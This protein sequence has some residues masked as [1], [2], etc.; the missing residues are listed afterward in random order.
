MFLAC[1]GIF[2]AP[3]ALSVGHFL[4]YSNP[5]PKHVDALAPPYLLTIQLL[6]AT[7]ASPLLICAGAVVRRV[8]GTPMLP[9][10]RALA[11]YA[12]GLLTA[13]MLIF[14]NTL[15]LGSWLFD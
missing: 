10:R 1:F 14:G 11:G 13:C 4:S 6:L 15:G 2:L 5:D 12:T 7:A 3:V 9:E 8:R